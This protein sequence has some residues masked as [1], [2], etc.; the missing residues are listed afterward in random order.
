MKNALKI[1][2]FTL[3]SIVG[4]SGLGYLYGG[5]DVFFGTLILLSMLIIPTVIFS[6]I[7]DVH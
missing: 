7:A 5:Q 4:F 3:L 2:G 6:A 1:I